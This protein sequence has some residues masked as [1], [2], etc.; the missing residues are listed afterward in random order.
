MTCLFPSLILRYELMNLVC[1]KCNEEP[2]QQ[3]NKFLL[4]CSCGFLTVLSSCPTKIVNRK[5]RQLFDLIAEKPDEEQ[6]FFAVELFRD[7]LKGRAKW[8][9]DTKTQD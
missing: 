2:T 6:L 8:K 7:F 5:G 3:R 4:E 9:L 1:H